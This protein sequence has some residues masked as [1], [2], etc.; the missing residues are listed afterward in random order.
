MDGVLAILDLLDGSRERVLAAIEALPDE[1]LLAEKAVGR[2]SVADVLA[3]Q[4]AWEAELVTGLMRLDQGKK[5]EKLLAA[6][7]E[8]EAYDARRY[9]DYRG[10]ALDLIFDD[11]QQVRMQLEAWLEEFSERDLMNRQRFQWLGGKS[12]KQ[13]LTAVSSDRELAYA[14]DLERFARQWLDEHESEDET[15]PAHFIPLTAVSPEVDDN[16]Q[17]D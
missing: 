3:L 4:V 10:R 14:P 2:Y 8:P 7:A 11:L 9:E 6:L 1:A 16:E 17:P 13:V 5:P 15:E 12:L